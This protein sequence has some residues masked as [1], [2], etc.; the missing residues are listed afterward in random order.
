MESL[1][2]NNFLT[3]IIILNIGIYRIKIAKNICIVSKFF[4]PLQLYYAKWHFNH[5]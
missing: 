3:L 2:D 1:I 5:K 4:R